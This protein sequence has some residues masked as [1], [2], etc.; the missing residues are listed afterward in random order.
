MTGR[1]DNKPPNAPVE[2]TAVYERG[3]L[4]TKIKVYILGLLV[5]VAGISF[6][7]GYNLGKDRAWQPEPSANTAICSSSTGVTGT[8]LGPNALWQPTPDGTVIQLVSVAG[9]V[10]PQASVVVT[11]EDGERKKHG[12]ELG[13][14]IEF[15]SQFGSYQIQILAIRVEPPELCLGPPSRAP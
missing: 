2:I 6:T 12:L 15:R 8:P 10:K 1:P 4:T 7:I 13:H 3:P 11:D 14:T 9:V 5:S